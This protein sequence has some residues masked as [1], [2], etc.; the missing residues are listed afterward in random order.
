MPASK[1][2]HKTAHKY[3]RVKW[4]SRKQKG[5]PYYI[6]KCMLPGCTHWVARDLV[7]GNMSICWRCGK[8]FQ[9][10]LASTYLAKPHCANCTERKDGSHD[11]GDVLSN[12]DELLG[13]LDA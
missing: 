12:L 4:K 11:S 7:V 2:K 9:M 13:G 1:N 8:E 10:T 3:L 6:F 5:E